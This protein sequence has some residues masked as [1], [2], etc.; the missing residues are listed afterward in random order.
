M[1]KS[2]I[3]FAI[4][5]MY[6][7]CLDAKEL[8]PLAQKLL[9]GKT[10]QIDTGFPYYQN[11]SVESIASE[12]A[13]NGY[14]G[15]YYFVMIG[16]GVR[17]G[18]IDELH[19]NNL[20]VGLMTLPSIVYATDESLAGLLP[21]N[22]REWLIE[23]TGPDM[24]I[25]RFI[26]FIYPE[27][28]EWLKKYLNNLLDNNSFDGFTFAEVMYPL[29][30]GPARAVP[31]YGDVSANFQE[32]FKKATFNVDFPEFFDKS[33]PNY[34]KTNTKLYNDLVEYRVKTINDFYDDIV[35]SSTGVRANHPNLMFATWTLGIN[36]PNGVDKLREWEGND[37]AAMIAQVKPDMHFIQT[38][39]PDW[40]NPTLVSSY[41]LLYKPFFDAIRSTNPQ[42]KI[43]MQADFGST[44]AARR[45]N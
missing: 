40:N 13:L 4:L 9:N 11:R 8:S 34:F 28:N 10:V 33:S 6:S 20:A 7:V 39:A 31:F 14:E 45:S 27:Y 41:P 29:Y 2:I 26:G 22:H 23:F 3:L 19:K 17:D 15:V 18:L 37:I 32:A 12:I 1:K 16:G 43:G 24:S 25:Y 38:H 5:I 44:A 35:N 36:I 42:M 30:D 21:A